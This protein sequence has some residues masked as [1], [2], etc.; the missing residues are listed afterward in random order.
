M[1]PGEIH[2]DEDG[3]T[4][5]VD[6]AVTEDGRTTGVDAAAEDGRTTGVDAAVTEDTGPRN[7]RYNAGARLLPLVCQHGYR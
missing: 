2:P 6:A 1:E 3:R 7:E 4:T 5:G